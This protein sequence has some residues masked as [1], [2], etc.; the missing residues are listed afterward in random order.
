MTEDEMVGWHHQLDGDEFEQALGVG[1]GQGSLAC[2]SPCSWQRVRHK[3]ANEQKQ[4][5]LVF[6]DDPLTFQFSMEYCLS[7]QTLLSLPDTCTT[8]H[9]FCF[10]LAASFFL[11]LFLHFPQQHIGHLTCGRIIFWSHIFVPFCTVHG[12][13]EARTLEQFAMSSSGNGDSNTH[14]NNNSKHCTKYKQILQR[15]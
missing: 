8:E 4:I 2:Y 5:Y 11:E 9:C 14:G 6:V 12:V 15:Q 10:S 3:F 13:F 1:D 7:H